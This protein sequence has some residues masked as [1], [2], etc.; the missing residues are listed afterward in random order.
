MIVLITSAGIYSTTSNGSI[1]LAQQT[2]SFISPLCLL[3]RNSDPS[4]AA[5]EWQAK[6]IWY[7]R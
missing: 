1:V 6:S 4:N 7:P 2:Q 3:L 5:P